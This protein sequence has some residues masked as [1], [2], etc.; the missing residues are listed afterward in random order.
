MILAAIFSIPFGVFLV[1][2]GLLWEPQRKTRKDLKEEKALQLSDG[3]EPTE[4]LL[5]DKPLTPEQTRNYLRRVLMR[6]LLVI[7][8]SLGILVGFLSGIGSIDDASA[9]WFFFGI[10]GAMLL[11][12][13]RAEKTRR[14]LVLWMVAFVGFLI[15]RTAEY[16]GS[17]SEHE[18]GLLATSIANALFWY[19]IGRRF[20][21]ASSD[22][23][24]VIGL[25]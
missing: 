25:E 7:F 4:E 24:E 11:V 22:A 17:E 21:P 12:V 20:P 2:L 3:I 19:L 8:G 9:F 1:I 15:W 6:V 23:I 5:E 10:Y 18:W 14:I 13:Q 16:R